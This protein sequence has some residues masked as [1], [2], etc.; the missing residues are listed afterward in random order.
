M[1]GADQKHIL[2]RNFERD[3]NA[4]AM[5][6]QDPTVMTAATHTGSGNGFDLA[7]NH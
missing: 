2:Y 4:N 1:N 6:L 3:K 7:T 5:R